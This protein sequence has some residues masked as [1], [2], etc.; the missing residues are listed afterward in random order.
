MIKYN[1]A[2]LSAT[3]AEISRSN[4]EIAA[5]LD[6]LRSYLQPLVS[7][8]TGTAAESYQTLQM[9]WDRS[10]AELNQVLQTVSVVVNNSSQ[11]MNDTNMAAARSWS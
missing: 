8:W 10:A 11:A 4:A 5:S 3:S 1:F 6:Q 2:S 7:Q 9:Q